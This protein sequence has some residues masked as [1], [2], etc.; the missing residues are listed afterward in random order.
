MLRSLLFYCLALMLAPL[1]PGIINRTKAL[2]AGRQGP[3]LFQLY[4]DLWKLLRKGAVYS[5]TMTWVFRAGPMLG[6]AA[7]LAAL[8]FVPLGHYPALVSFSGD[9]LLL[10]YFLGVMRFATVL[11]ALDTGSSF[12][13]M[14]RFCWGLRPWP[15][16]RPICRFRE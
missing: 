13:G 7:V 5:K 15:G 2:F 3:S 4:Y 11:A 6:L 12:E 14:G 8:S 10:A 1:L 9:F 16:R